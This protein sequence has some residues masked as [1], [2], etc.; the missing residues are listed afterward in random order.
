MPRR[1]ALNAATSVTGRVQCPPLRPSR[2]LLRLS[3]GGLN[4]RSDRASATDQRVGTNPGTAVSAG[5]LS[6]DGCRLPSPCHMT[7]EPRGASMTD[8]SSDFRQFCAEQRWFQAIDFGD[9]VSSGRF[10]PGTP[11][12]RTLYGVMELLTAMDLSGGRVLDIGTTDGLIAFGAKAL[13][14]AEV[15]AV[16]SYHRPTFGAAVRARARHRLPPERPGQGPARPIRAG[17]LRRR[18]VRRRHLPH[19][20]SVLGVHRVSQTAQARRVGLRR[21]GDQARRRASADTQQRD[22]DARQGEVHVLGGDGTRDGRNGAAPALRPAATRLQVQGSFPVRATVLAQAT[23]PGE[24]PDRSEMLT[25]I[26]EVDFCDFEFQFKNL[27]P[28]PAT[29]TTTLGTVPSARRIDPLAE[30]VKFPYHPLDVST[31]VGSTSWAS[32]DGNF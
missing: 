18:G 30:S 20:Q 1:C 17:V 14:A 4:W 31:S 22:R 23:D 19:A 12:N 15:V 6:A 24:I 29:S 7:D 2:R 11:Q 26:H 21:V 32:A 5:Q 8:H 10:P 9:V 3:R 27:P 28:H 13:G 25:R 16:D